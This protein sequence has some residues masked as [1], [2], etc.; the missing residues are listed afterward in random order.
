MADRLIEDRFESLNRLLWAQT[1]I[2]VSLLVQMMLDTYGHTEFATGW[3]IILLVSFVLNFGLGFGLICL[4]ETSWTRRRVFVWGYLL[5]GFLNLVTFSLKGIFNPY[6]DYI[7]FAL[8][9]NSGYGIFL[10]LVYRRYERGHLE[11]MTE[12]AFP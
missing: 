12:D 8:T 10:W 9:V 7:G 1:G 5:L 3:V 11:R 2:S 6:A 4:K